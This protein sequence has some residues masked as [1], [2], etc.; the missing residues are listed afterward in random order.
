MQSG[1]RTRLAAGAV[2]ALASLTAWAQPTYQQRQVNGAGATLFVDFFELPGSTGDFLDIDGDG[3]AGAIDTSGDGIPDSFDQLAITNL[4]TAAPTSYGFTLEATQEIPAPTLPGGYTGGGSASLTLNFVT[5]TLSWN[6]S[7][8]GLTGAATACH[9][10]GPAAAGSTAGVQVDIG[11]LSGGLASPM[12]G[13]VV[14]TPEQLK[15]FGQGLWYVNIHT[16]AN[17]AG[18]IRGQ[19]P[20]VVIANNWWTVQYRSV[21]SIEGFIEFMDYQACADLPEVVTSERGLINRTRFASLGVPL[22][23]GFPACIDDT[24]GD[25]IPN[26]S[27]TPICPT[28]IDFANVDVVTAWAVKND[29]ATANNWDRKPGQTGYGTNPELTL[30]DPAGNQNGESTNLP[31]LTRACGVTLNTN[32]VSPDNRTIYDTGIAYSPVTPIENRG[33]GIATFK[34][35]DLQYLLIS[36]RLSSGENLFAAVRDVG[37]GTRNAY[38]NSLG[39][40]ASRANGDKVGRRINVDT[41]TRLGPF[42]QVS[43]CGGSGIIETAVRS[44]RLCVGY[45]GVAGPSRAVADTYSGQYDIPSVINNHIVSASITPVRPTLDAIIFNSSDTTGWR[46]GGI[47]TLT[48][49]GDPDANRAITD[50]LYNSAALPLARQDPADLINNIVSSIVQFTQNPSLPANDRTAGEL[51]GRQFFLTAAVEALPASADPE[52]YLP[53]ATVPTLVSFV[54]ANNE[55]RATGPTPTP[56]YQQINP[57]TGLLAPLRQT[58]PTGPDYPG[59]LY[60]DGSTGSSYTYKDRSG[61]L[62][63]I[64]A[65]GILSSR[66][67]L[68]GDLNRDGARS[69]GDVAKL[70][71]LVNL[72]TDANPAN[73]Y[74]FEFPATYAAGPTGTMVDDVIVPWVMGDING[75][76]NVNKRDVRY[77]CDGLAMVSGV[78]NRKTGFTNADNASLALGGPLNYF[79][80]TLVRPDS[81][82]VAYSAGASRLDVAGGAFITRGSEPEGSDGTVNCVD[83]TYIFNNAGDWANPNDAQRIDL[84]ADMNGD[85]K[86][87]GLDIAELYIALNVPDFNLDGVVNESELGILLGNWQTAQNYCGGDANGDGVVNESDLGILLGNWQSTT[88]GNFSSLL[89]C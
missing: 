15:D 63:N 46:I 79:G 59:N 55:L 72:V 86:V 20:I 40:D 80:T 89:P 85:L 38:S 50:P 10:H 44:N 17:G 27:N 34:A 13:S 78:L 84:S 19:V 66:N 73:D 41:R 35:T 29:D 21:G 54:Q 33:V 77:F 51:L 3:Q 45:T 31:S 48:T 36:G 76:G 64:A 69:A 12:I 56:T 24:D 65:T 23:T 61:V 6:I 11:T 60:N 83:A 8:S 82:V 67:K 5:R 4:N 71:E 49:I 42:H 16:A 81:S 9:F 52:S 74:D 37:S 88:C 87:N 43:A 53:N 1:F 58:N 47:Q 7:Y 68:A 22:A 32:T 26:N 25:L 70:V 57:G 62:R 75:D 30:G 39:V 18:E 14:L 2:I 28:T